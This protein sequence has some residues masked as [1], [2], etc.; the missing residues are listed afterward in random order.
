[1]RPWQGQTALDTSESE[2]KLKAEAHALGLPKPLPANDRLAMRVALEAS[3]GPLD[4]RDE[5]C[6]TYLALKLEEVEAGEMSAVWCWVD[7]NL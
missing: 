6:A 5:P 4:A 7:A 1:M 3:L 2:R